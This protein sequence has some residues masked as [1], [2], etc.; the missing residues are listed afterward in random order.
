MQHALT[1]RNNNPADTCSVDSHSF[2]P[3]YTLVLEPSRRHESTVD[4]LYTSSLTPSTPSFPT[5][6]HRARSTTLSTCLACR[7]NHP[8]RL[9][10]Y[11]ANPKRITLTS[12]LGL[13]PTCNIHWG[14]FCSS[15]M[16][17]QPRLS[18]DGSNAS[19]YFD[20]LKCSSVGDTDKL[21]STRQL[22]S[23]TCMD[24]RSEA[25]DF[26]IERLLV[27][28]A[29]G[30]RVRG[31]NNDFQDAA[32]FTEYVEHGMGTARDAALDSV[33]QLWLENQTR[34]PEL[35]Y[36]ACEM[37]RRERALRKKFLLTFQTESDR[38]R[39]LR[40]QHIAEL[41]GED[42]VID[43]WE[44]EQAMNRMYRAWAKGLF[45][46]EG[47]GDDEWLSAGDANALDAKV[48]SF[49]G[50]ILVCR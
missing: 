6:F 45:E 31:D 5:L 25:I 46:V 40:H 8:S 34:W 3:S 17:E 7:I 9:G 41:R 27:R 29:R 47:E 15:C 14:N 4:D 48:G 16:L 23:M 30:G 24:C 49:R 12:K 18:R 38:E 37:Q 33:Q 19:D 13:A 20:R 44:D 43:P 26:E 35:R 11:P 36:T 21:D 39:S 1:A 32:A 10:L 50:S 28:C 2:W 22:K 42:S